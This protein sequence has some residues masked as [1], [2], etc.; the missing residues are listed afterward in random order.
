MFQLN[1]EEWLTI[2]KCKNFTSSWGGRRKLLLHQIDPEL[3]K[4]GTKEKMSYTRLLQP[5]VL[6][7]F[8]I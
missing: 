6:A 4:T 3:E 2:L 8:S 5:N 1:E 7:H